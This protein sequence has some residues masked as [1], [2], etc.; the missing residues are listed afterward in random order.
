MKKLLMLILLINLALANK[1]SNNDEYSFFYI[2]H[3]A[4]KDSPIIDI[5]KSDV[6]ASKAELK[7]RKSTNYPNFYM[8]ANTGYSGTYDDYAGSVYVGNDNL[9]SNNDF[10]NS[11][12]LILSY[13]IYKFG[14]DSYAI[15]AAK[16]GVKSKN[17]EVCVKSLELSLEVLNAFH[18]ALTLKNRIEIYENLKVINEL[19]SNYSVRLN[20]AGELDKISTT[21]KKLDLVNLNSQ[22]LKSKT[23]LRA[24]LNHLSA[25]SSLNLIESNLPKSFNV[26]YTYPKFIKFE[27][28]YKS[29]SLEAQEISA[30]YNITSNER[31]KYPTI[32]LYARYDFYGQD[33]DSFDRAISDTKKHGYRVGINFTWSLFDGFRKD[34]QLDSSK[35]QLEKVILEKRQAKLEYEKEIAD[36]LAFLQ[37]KDETENI[38]EELVNESK[39]NEANIKRLQKS[40]E[41]SKLEALDSII[42]TL[43]NIIELTDYKL[44]SEAKLIRAHILANQGAGCIGGVE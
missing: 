3:T 6:K 31:S 14:S 32:S 21:N 35:A 20:E 25:L 12:S 9:S 10:Q 33:R 42:K 40:G 44:E 23:E 38:L 13:D 39:K 1:K 19:I 43:Q 16:E 24:I 4:L 37:N 28:T 27:N 7:A 22:I 26:S 11:V 15:E 5:A 18:R 30:K 34:A 41:K 36:L 17:Y 8:S 29:K 2:L